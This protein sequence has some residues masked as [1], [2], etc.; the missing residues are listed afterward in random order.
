MASLS[1]QLS[2]LSQAVS[3][4]SQGLSAAGGGGSVK[5]RSRWVSTD[6]II[7]ATALTNISGL[8]LSVSA[9]GLYKMEAQIAVNRGNTS[10]PV[11]LGMTFPSMKKTRGIVRYATSATTIQGTV[12]TMG[13]HSPWAGDS[14]SASALVSLPATTTVTFLSTNAIFEGFFFASATG[15]L[16]MQAAFGA[17]TA[18][19]T[20]TNG[21]YLRL[22]RIN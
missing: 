20:I 2:V 15:T 8:S 11:K 4:L 9:G 22:V 3:V 14:A 7:S 13:I 21:S 5:T 10:T 19:G 16:Q 17:T 1:D 18:A 12:S 6:Q